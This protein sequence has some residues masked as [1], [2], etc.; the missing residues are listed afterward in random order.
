MMVEAV[1]ERV[2]HGAKRIMTFVVCLSLLEHLIFI[3]AL[4]CGRW[5]SGGWEDCRGEG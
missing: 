1:T 2:T 5:G 3:E 4:G